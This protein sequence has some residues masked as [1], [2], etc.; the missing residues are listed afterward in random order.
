MDPSMFATL[1]N[2]KFGSSLGG[3]L[4]SALGGGGPNVSS[5][6]V[7]SYGV[8]DS[9]GWAVNIGAGSQDARSSPTHTAAPVNSATGTPESSMF[10][11]GIGGA[12]NQAGV[13]LLP[14]LLLAGVAVVMIA[15][16]RK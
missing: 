14:G 10:P 15:K 12:M 13:G 7:A 6:S 9:S 8:F 4:G 5:A 3:S 16:G 1:F 2:S 11:T